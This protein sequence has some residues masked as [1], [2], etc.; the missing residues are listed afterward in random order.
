MIS[1]HLELKITRALKVFPVL[2]LLGA[3]Q[4]GKTTLVKL[5]TDK[6]SKKIHY[7]DLERPTSLAALKHDTEAYLE[8]YINHCV[9]IDEV[10]R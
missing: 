6:L 9:I 5:M 2:V 3:R 1:R 4:V 7:I 8:T 10:Q